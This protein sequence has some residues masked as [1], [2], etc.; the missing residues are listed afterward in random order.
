MVER[1]KFFSSGHK[2]SPK[3]MVAS[4][5]LLRTFVRKVI[6]LFVSRLLPLTTYIRKIKVAVKDQMK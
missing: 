5:V 3:G 4:P 2:R 6:E 1:N